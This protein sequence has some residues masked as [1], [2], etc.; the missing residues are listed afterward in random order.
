MM[1]HD[2]MLMGKY[3]NKNILNSTA[4]SFISGST[5]AG[6]S[7]DDIFDDFLSD[8]FTSKLNISS[9]IQKSFIKGDKTS[10]GVNN[11]LPLD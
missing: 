5:A 7:K 3:Q 10:G 4:K 6:K 8:L 2:Q 11:T 1:A 9:S